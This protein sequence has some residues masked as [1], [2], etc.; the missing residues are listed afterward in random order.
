MP[1][2]EEDVFRIASRTNSETQHIING[3]APRHVRLPSFRM[4]AASLFPAGL[5]AVGLVFR[6]REV[7]VSSRSWLS[8]AMRKFDAHYS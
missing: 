5:E 4:L 7:V 8:P 6:W 2:L 1:S 3:E